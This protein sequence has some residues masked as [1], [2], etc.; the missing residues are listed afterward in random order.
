MAWAP[1]GAS[2]AT[3]SDDGTIKLWDG[4]T[5][6]LLG[7]MESAHDGGVRAHAQKER[8]H[9]WVCTAMCA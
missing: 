7:T 4:A 6:A 9:V 5:L 3:K 1:N 8:G 2:L